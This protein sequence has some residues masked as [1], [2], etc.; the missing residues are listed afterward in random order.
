MSKPA[1]RLAAVAAPLLLALTA[2]LTTS[3]AAPLANPNPAPAAAATTP[4]LPPGRFAPADADTLA[5]YTREW[6]QHNATLANPFFEGRAPGTL[7]N[8][9]A[10]DYLEF[11][12]KDAGLKPAFTSESG[13]PSFRQAFRAP[14]SR[15]SDVTTIVEQAVTVP[16]V[17]LRADDDFQATAYSGNATAEGPLAF[18]GYSISRG[19]DG[20]STYGDA[21]NP[22]DGK[23][24][25][26]LRFEP[27][28]EEGKSQWSPRGWSPAAALDGKLRAAARAGAKAIILV[29][30]PGADDDRVDELEGLDLGGRRALDIPV[31]QMTPAAADKLVKA[32]DS[33]GRSL[34]DLRKLADT[35]GGIINLGEKPATITVALDTQPLMTDNVA[36]V[37]PGRGKLKDEYLVIGAHY[38]HVGYGF[39]G[40]RDNEPGKIHPGADDNASGTSGLLLLADKLAEDYAGLPADAD[41]RSILFIGFS[42]EE[43]GLNG[44][45]HYTRNPIVAPEQHALMINLDMIGRLRE[46]KVELQGLD[47]ADGMKE[48]AQPYLDS[49]GMTVALKRGG[50]GPS[51]HASFFAADIPVMFFFTGLHTE[52][53]TSRDTHDTINAE[54]AAQIVDLVHRIAFDFST[55]EKAF[56]FSGGRS[57]E[58]AA[59]S[60]GDA[61]PAPA[62]GGR[63]RFGI[64]PADYTGEEKG[65][66]IGQVFPGTPAAAA[67]VLAG[68]MLVEWNGTAIDDVEAWMPLFSAAK[69]GDV[70]KI[71]VVREGKR[72]P[73]EVTLVARGNT[74]Q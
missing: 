52:Y 41:A 26:V 73:L 9:M 17:T 55:R 47:T 32:T 24:A 49:S 69:A 4:S 38:D 11:Y 42:A 19:R 50:S 10:A 57:A 61:A 40:S 44:S 5:A 63:I 12:F 16:G 27:M 71:V 59:H 39:F 21:E 14:V 22:L 46:G 48:W 36:A 6:K 15:A 72:V 1:T 25:V 56:P 33:E 67:G 35:E 8:K 45:R 51:D 29:N 58:V 65:V 64:M 7:G 31:I 3:L 30:A 13:K 54:G 74:D 28:T 70:V 62:S 34:L 60:G 66:P 37:L 18:A 68:D 53:H 20:Y 43:S 23:I 2:G